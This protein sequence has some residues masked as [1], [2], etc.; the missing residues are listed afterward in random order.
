MFK[1]K[2]TDQRKMKL[3]PKNC[4]R[5]QKLN[6]NEAFEELEDVYATADKQNYSESSGTTFTS[7]CADILQDL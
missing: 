4:Y 7:P 1:L 2:V 5:S 3:H 6:S